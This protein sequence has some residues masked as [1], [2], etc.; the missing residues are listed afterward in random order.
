MSRDAALI[1]MRPAIPVEPSGTDAERFLHE[2]LRPVL[3]LQ[4]ETLL[5]LVGHH[6]AGLVPGFA[7]FAPDDRRERL[8]AMLRTDSR[9][10]RTL[11][12]T[13]LGVLTEDE[14]AFALRHEAE[15]R[16]RIAALLAERIAGQAD[17]VAA[18]ARA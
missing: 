2:T 13:V 12:G 3:K 5:A 18:L 8:A 10:K 6:V 15:V 14:L 7:A 1:A 11:V 16:R 17:A 4:N 9:L